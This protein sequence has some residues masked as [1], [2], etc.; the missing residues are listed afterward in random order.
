MSV[1][2]LVNF[3]TIA[4]YQVMADMKKKLRR[5]QQECLDKNC[6]KKWGL[7]VFLRKKK[8]IFRGN[9]TVINGNFTII[10]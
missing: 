10:F 3:W 6:D 1:H 4:K 7:I 9:L 2:K 5:S 8:I